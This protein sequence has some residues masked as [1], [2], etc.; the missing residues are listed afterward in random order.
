[1]HKPPTKASLRLVVAAF[2]AGLLP[3]T[4][5]C[6]GD[7]LGLVGAV[8]PTF[9]GGGPVFLDAARTVPRSTYLNGLLIDGQGRLVATGATTDANGK[10]AT[11]VA[12]FGAGGESDP[13]FGENGVRIQ[14]LS[15]NPVSAYARIRRVF[16]VSRGRWGRLRRVPSAVGWPSRS[17]CDDPRRHWFAE[18]RLRSGGLLTLS[19]A[20]RR[21][22]PARA[23][24]RGA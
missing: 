21:P 1:M 15:S 24:H 7:A 19:P 2:V 11:L 23:A 6:A 16:A 18:P 17:G 3:G 13:A 4:D 12:R 9:N 5:A 20:L 8:D 14:Q 22:T 10:S